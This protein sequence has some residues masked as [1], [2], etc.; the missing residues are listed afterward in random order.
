MVEDNQG[1]AYPFW[2][3]SSQKKK[4]KKEASAT[5]ITHKLIKESDKL[6]SNSDLHTYKE[7][8]D[9]AEKYE[10]CL[11]KITQHYQI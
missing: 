5:A 9:E 10:M 6:L 3:V 11:P 8:V 7:A 2:K 1:G 4:S